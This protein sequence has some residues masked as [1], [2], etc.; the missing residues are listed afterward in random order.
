MQAKDY[1]YEVPVEKLPRAM[2]TPKELVKQIEGAL[3]KK[4]I[5]NMKKEAVE[6]PVLKKKISFLQCYLCPNFVRR[7]R[8]IVYCRGEPLE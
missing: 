6:C 2:R 5:S 3:S 7:V 1:K 8:G 4:M